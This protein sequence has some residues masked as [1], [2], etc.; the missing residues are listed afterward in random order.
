MSSSGSDCLIAT[1]RARWCLADSIPYSYAV[2]DRCARM[3]RNPAEL[4][5]QQNKRILKLVDVSQPDSDQPGG[6]D[7]Q[8]RAMRDDRC[9][10]FRAA[11]D[12][13]DRPPIE[14]KRLEAE[15]TH[16]G[17]GEV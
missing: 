10:K 2:R 13:F 1:T 14:Q 15:L 9:M 11:H 12:T 17:L 3:G 6:I 16:F 5:V 8:V 7:W 4:R